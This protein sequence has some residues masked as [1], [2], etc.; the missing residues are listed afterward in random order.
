MCNSIKKHSHRLTSRVRVE[1]DP[2]DE[3][4][5]AMVYGPNG[6]SAT[7]FCAA[8]VGELVGNSDD[9]YLNDI[10]I[11]ELHKL[12]DEAERFYQIARENSPD[13]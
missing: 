11:N 7:F 1:F 12:T 5:P 6:T 4:T 2:Q 13:Y 10:E 3:A 9:Y 8:D